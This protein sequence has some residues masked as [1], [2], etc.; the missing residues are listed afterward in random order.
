MKLPSAGALLSLALSVHTVILCSARV[1]Q[2]SLE[3]HHPEEVEVKEG[4]Q[5]VLK[6]FWPSITKQSALSGLTQS[7]AREG[8]GSSDFFLIKMQHIFILIRRQVRHQRGLEGERADPFRLFLYM[9][10]HLGSTPCMK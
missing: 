6:K 9:I 4:L 2:G 7:S 3:T 1:L 10:L 5:Q 8:R